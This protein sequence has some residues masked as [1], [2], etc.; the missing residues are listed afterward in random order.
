MLKKDL[1]QAVSSGII[2]TFN[3]FTRGC[4]FFLERVHE[5]EVRYKTN[6]NE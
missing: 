4:Q 2:K 6:V 1:I 5:N 3:A